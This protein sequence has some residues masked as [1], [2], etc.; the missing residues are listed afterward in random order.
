MMCCKTRPKERKLKHG[1]IVS[2]DN[3]LSDLKSSFG[4]QS[5]YGKWA[6]QLSDSV[7]NCDI[8]ASSPEEA[9]RLAQWYAY[10]DYKELK[11]YNSNE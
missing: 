9:F 10:L 8:Q 3:V 5:E 11:S 1:S 4:S 2:G 7:K 6:I